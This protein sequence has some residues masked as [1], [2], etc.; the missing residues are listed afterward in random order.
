MSS[1][2]GRMVLP[3]VYNFFTMGAV[4]TPAATAYSP[5]VGI[6][7]GIITG[8]GAVVSYFT[9]YTLTIRIPTE[10]EIEE[11]LNDERD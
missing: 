5:S 1:V 4:L 8:L 11:W 6:G 3:G 2:T 9:S 10:E 7:V